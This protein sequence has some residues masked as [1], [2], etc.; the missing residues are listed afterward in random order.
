ME[1]AKQLSKHFKHAETTKWLSTLTDEDVSHILEQYYLTHVHIHMGSP[2]QMTSLPDLKVP[3]PAKTSYEIGRIGEE[4][5]QHILEQKYKTVRPGAHAGD[6]ILQIDF[7][8]ILVEV[9]NYAS[10]IPTVEVDK[11]IDDIRLHNMCG[12]LLISLRSGIA[13]HKS[14]DIEQSMYDGRMCPIVYLAFPASPDSSTYS[15]LIYTAIEL[16]QEYNMYYK[17]KICKL[18]ESQHEIITLNTDEI[19]RHIDTIQTMRQQ[20]ILLRQH[21][22]EILDSLIQQMH[23][24]TSFIKRNIEII[25]AT[26]EERKIQNITIHDVVSIA[27]INRDIIQQM[28]EEMT[29]KLH[30]RKINTPITWKKDSA[31]SYRCEQLDVILTYYKT[32]IEVD[33]RLDKTRM[34]EQLKDLFDPTVCDTTHIKLKDGYI[35]FILN[36][37]TLIHVLKLV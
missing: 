2:I 5:I 17:T 16:I 28:L 29:R 21:N 13:R 36:S 31:K 1:I 4:E 37:M 34:H 30:E 11:F 15:Y 9:K 33:I 25:V 24:H 18:E 27:P 35:G 26:L 19:S 3:V 22:N 23:L 6:F 32:K 7:Q 8:N 12:G 10:T 14:F 20:L